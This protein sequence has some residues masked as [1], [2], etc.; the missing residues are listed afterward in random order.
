MTEPR[1]DITRLL[2]ATGEEQ[3]EALEAVAH[4][5]MDDLRR[6]AGAHCRHEA[7]DL[8]LQPTAVVNEAWLRLASQD[9]C[10]WENREHFLSVASIAM[11]R[12]LIDHARKRQ[13]L[14]R[15]GDHQ[16]VHLTGRHGASREDDVNLDLEALSTALEDLEALDP[17][18]ARIVDLRFLAGLTV[19]QVANV[20]GQ[21]SATI[22][23][24]WAVARGWL[25]AR[26]ETTSG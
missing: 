14:I 25:R 19:E 7:N 11:R 21:S 4:E 12:L 22:K 6:I 26:L 18:L 20:T 3:A 2:N 10:K 23:R 1:N 24:R 13:S 9:R 17:E 5:L 15:G 8:T 16:R